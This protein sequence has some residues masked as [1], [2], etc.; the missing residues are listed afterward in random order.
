MRE[1][2]GRVCCESVLQVGSIERDRQVMKVGD[3][4][5]LGCP[6]RRTLAGGTAVPDSSDRLSLAEPGSGG[7][8]LVEPLRSQRQ[9][10]L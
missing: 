8:Q 7:G 4:A 6:G 2:V 3:V 5:G 9:P 1:S 10:G